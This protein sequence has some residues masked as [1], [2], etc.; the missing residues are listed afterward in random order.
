MSI[1][2]RIASGV[3]ASLAARVIDITTNAALTVILARY[4]LSPN[5]FGTLFIAISVLGVASMFGTL[6]LPSSAAKYIAE[7]AEI[8]RAQVPQILAHAT[9]YMLLLGVTVAVA[10]ALGSSWIA[11]LLNEEAIAPLLVV[12]SVYLVFEALSKYL[13]S[14]FQG[15]NQVPLS[16]L[17]NSISAVGRLVFAV[18][19]T[20]IGFGAAGALTGYTIGFAL[21][22]CVGGWILYSRFYSTFPSAPSIED[23]LVR[24]MLEYSVPLTATR[25][26]SVIDKKVDTILVGALLNPVAAGWYTIGKQV[27]DAAVAPA[28]SLGFTISPAL[29][30]KK[31]GDRLEVAAR[32]YEQALEHVLILYIPATVGLILVAE[33]MVSHVFGTDYA[34][35]IPVVQVLSLFVLANSVIKITSDG[36][37]YLGRARSRAIFKGGMAVSNFVLNLLLI[38]TIG[39]VGAAVATVVTF[40]AY[41]VLCVYIITD[42]LPVTFTA[43]G[44]SVARVS[45]IAAVMGAIVFSLLPYVTG[46]VSLFGVIG[47]GM[48]V[49]AIGSIAW[50][51][52]DF[53]RVWSVIGPSRG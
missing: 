42:E 53:R 4:L 22:V 3:K 44:R 23:G 30:E 6:G 32:L 13:A 45:I 16:A 1:A 7:Y 37:D 20:A 38:P 48:V 9:L 25:G 50:G 18:A 21:S 52:V 39:V 49:W 46:L 43:I 12:G 27:S 29:G 11:S 40:S 10:M 41:T 36:L 8:D 15:L 17:V 33:P 47:A 19:L 31:A 14:V 5:Q 2:D 24:R 34:G 28:S 51:L 26:A 35:A